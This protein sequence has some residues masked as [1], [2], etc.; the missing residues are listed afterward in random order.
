M[1]FQVRVAYDYY[2]FGL[3]WQN[4]ADFQTPEGIHDHAYQD[5]EYQWNEF[6]NNAGL[7]LYDFHARMYD[8]ATAT[9][10]VPDPAE[11]FSNPYLAMGN[12]PVIG[13]DPDGQWVHILVGAV[14]G[15]VV[16]T[17]VHWDEITAG[18]QFNWEEFGK[19][20][21]LGAAAGA[22]TALTAGGLTA[23]AGGAGAGGFAS[24][25]VTG[26]FSTT[27]GNIVLSEGNHVAFGDPRWTAGQY[28]LSAG[29]GGVVGG[30]TNGLVSKSHGNGFWTGSSPV[31]QSRS[32]IGGDYSGRTGQGSATPDLLYDE[33]GNL[34]HPAFKIFNEAAGEPL[35]IYGQTN[36]KI[37]FVRNFTHDEVVDYISAKSQVT[38]FWNAEGV[39]VIHETLDGTLLKYQAYPVSTSMKIPTV[40]VWY[41]NSSAEE[42]T[43]WVTLRF[44]P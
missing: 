30:V 33:Y 37:I 6:G 42:Y 19:A 5:K 39:E 28:A 11:Q 18:G 40:K 3:T 22:V 38:P 7:A 16:N 29:I 23:V 17:V 31:G 2:P 10:S 15:A 1:L 41:W 4:P 9:W 32:Y 12:N 44:T 13:V 36:G 20:A 34:R 24:G 21:G 35:E 27:A 26:A 25:F 43:H 14:V 8:P